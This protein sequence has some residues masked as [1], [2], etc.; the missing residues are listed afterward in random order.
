M[1]K[2]LYLHTGNLTHVSTPNCRVLIREADSLS[3]VCHSVTVATQ[4]GFQSVVCQLL[5][6]LARRE[7]PLVEVIQLVTESCINSCR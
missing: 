6:L 4:A 1:M 2:L 5:G 7:M 3:P